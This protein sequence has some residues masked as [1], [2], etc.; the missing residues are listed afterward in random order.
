MQLAGPGQGSGP[1]VVYAGIEASEVSPAP[2]PV[3]M[4]FGLRPLPALVPLVKAVM[5]AVPPISISRIRFTAA[6]VFIALAW[7]A[8]SV[9]I[10]MIRPAGILLLHLAGGA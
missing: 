9:L 1:G 6:P 5:S 7:S 3:R 10:P 4:P 8:A 2:A